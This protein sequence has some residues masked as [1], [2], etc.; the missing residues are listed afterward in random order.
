MMYLPRPS[1]SVAGPGCWPS[2]ISGSIA[3]MVLLLNAPAGDGRTTRGGGARVAL[4]CRQYSTAAFSLVDVLA[5]VHDC[6][7]AVI[8]GVRLLRCMGCGVLAAPDRVRWSA[9]ASPREVGCAGRAMCLIVMLTCL[10]ARAPTI[11]R[12]FP[13]SD[14]VQE[15]SVASVWQPPAA[16]HPSGIDPARNR[17]PSG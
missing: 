8:S 11:N 2:W 12:R 5:D 4:R 3:L 14:Q 15:P 16:R 13:G 9:Y 17:A 6:V 7:P 1:P 10:P